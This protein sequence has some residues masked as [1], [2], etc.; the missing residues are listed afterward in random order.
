[1]RN[2]TPVNA[3]LHRFWSLV[4][5]AVIVPGPVM[6]DDSP[7][8]LQS[9]EFS[10]T[11]G[12][13]L[14][15]PTIVEGDEKHSIKDPSIVWHDDEWHLFC[16]VR[17]NDRSH[18][19]V[20]L[21]FADW[22]D[23]AEAEQVMLPMHPGYYCAPQIFYFTPH[24]KWYLICQAAHDDWEPNY[25]P[26]FSTTQDVSDP[27]SWTPLEP[28]YGYRP[29][30]ITGWID[31]WVICDQTRAYLFFTS[32]DGNM[33]RSETPLEEFPYGWSTPVLA[34][35]GDIFEASHTYRLEGDGRYLTIVEA[36]GGHGWRYYKAYV[37]D[38]LDGE[39]QPLAAT[40]DECFANLRNVE[41]AAGRWTDSI[42]HGELLRS[43]N[44]E[45]L[46]VDPNNLQFLFQGVLERDRAGKSY[47]EI[48]WRLGLL[49]LRE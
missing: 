23:A 12:P 16:T 4:I 30:N 45:H 6:A 25:Q 19:V 24:E 18:G 31:F 39:W 3:H 34:L 43:G 1:M 9:G 20:Y 35:Q 44:D 27:E 41:Q 8:W 46:D 48:P 2:R 42:S 13:P 21:H 49:E 40:R 15:A 28:L 10:W 38:T 32:N 37:A 17:G 29:E 33:W 26:A 36:Q 5:V 22:S 47:G 7:D 14:A 11:L